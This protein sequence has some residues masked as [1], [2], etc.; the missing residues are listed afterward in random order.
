M[1]ITIE[2][3]E[4]L[5]L[6][7][8]HTARYTIYPASVATVAEVAPTNLITTVVGSILCPKCML[9]RDDSPTTFHSAEFYNY[10]AFDKR[11]PVRRV[12]KSDSVPGGEEVAH[13]P[14]TMESYDYSSESES[15]DDFQWE[16]DDN[17]HNTT[18]TMFRDIAKEWVG[19]T[20]EDELYKELKDCGQKEEGAGVAYFRNPP[21]VLA[22][23]NVG[24]FSGDKWLRRETPCGF[25][26]SEYVKFE[27]PDAGEQ[28]TFRNVD[29]MLKRAREIRIVPLGLRDAMQW[30]W[31]CMKCVVHDPYTTNNNG[32]SAWQRYATEYPN[33]LST[34]KLPWNV[35][36]SNLP[37][38]GFWVW[39][40][41]FGTDYIPEDFDEWTEAQRDNFVPS[42]K[43]TNMHAGPDIETEYPC[44]HLFSCPVIWKSDAQGFVGIEQE[45]PRKAGPAFDSPRSSTPRLPA[46]PPEGTMLSFPP[47]VSEGP[48][49]L[50]ESWSEIRDENHMKRDGSFDR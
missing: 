22:C 21:H 39:V 25:K 15:S 11:N 16:L 2:E 6:L 10:E 42:I 8:P 49:R 44:N 48:V 19:R 37:E 50:G 46:T 41:K 28:M 20:W 17:P 7:N 23:V 30:L 32:K 9:F 45:P 29:E 26:F 43:C 36:Q 12:P 14:Y 24:Q 38:D 33:Y 34:A 13:T 31:P 35:H 47:D 40:S 3:I 5:Q 4:K 18:M 27:L 1:A